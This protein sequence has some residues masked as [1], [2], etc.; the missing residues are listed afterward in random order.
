M[1]PDPLAVACPKCAQ[2]PLQACLGGVTHAERI[3]AAAFIAG[4]GN[5][6]PTSD[7]SFRAA[8]EKSGRV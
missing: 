1:I 6:T 7:E 2:Q 5:A 4:M 3:E 8:V